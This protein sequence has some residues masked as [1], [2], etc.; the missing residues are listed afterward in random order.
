MREEMWR[1][2]ARSFKW[3]GWGAY[4][5]RG[6]NKVGL[7]KV[8][9]PDDTPVAGCSGHGGAEAE[10]R[11]RPCELHGLWTDDPPVLSVTSS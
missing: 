2:G 6:R 4:V 8:D 5:D 3:R 1:C 9:R 7:H 11:K 10:A